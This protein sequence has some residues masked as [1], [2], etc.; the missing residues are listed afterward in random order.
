MSADTMIICKEDDSH[1][2]GKGRDKAFC[3]GETSMGEP[4]TEFNSW[5]QERFCKGPSMFEQMAGVK[6]HNHT[7]LTK[8]DVEA[9]KSSFVKLKH[10]DYI[11]KKEFFKWLDDHIGKHIS[12]ENW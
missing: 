7:K 4:H 5:F 2:E 3:I 12:T 10:K 8:E 1:Y 6:E 11:G 9:T